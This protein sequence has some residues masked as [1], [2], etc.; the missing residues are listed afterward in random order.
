ML[1]HLKIYYH[2]MKPEEP[3][4]DPKDPKPVKEGADTE[5]EKDDCYTTYSAAKTLPENLK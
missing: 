1:Y 2:P 3:G 4:P 5:V